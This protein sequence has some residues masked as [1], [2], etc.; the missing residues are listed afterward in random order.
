[1]FKL[2][3][4]QDFY[5]WAA[6]GLATGAFLYGFITANPQNSPSAKVS[7]SVKSTIPKSNTKYGPPNQLES[8]DFSNDNIGLYHP[9]YSGMAFHDGFRFTVA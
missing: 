4:N 1:M 8:V 3:K 9:Q 7:T 6:A 2:P 5:I